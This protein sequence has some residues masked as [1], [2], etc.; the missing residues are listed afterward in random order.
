[1]LSAT[2]SCLSNEHGIGRDR[3]PPGRPSVT[4]PMSA[5][6]GIAYRQ[7]V[8]IASAALLLACVG[9]GGGTLT[10]ADAGPARC[11]DGIRQSGE[12]CDLGAK[13]GPNAGCERD[14]TLSCVPSDPRR[15]DA[16]CDPHDPCKGLG[17]CGSDFRCTLSGALASGA[18]CGSGNICRGGACQA[19]VCGD[20]IVTAPEE[21]DDGINDGTQG[22]DSHCRFTCF[23]TDPTRDCTPADPCQGPST[24]DDSTHTCAPRTPLADGTS[25]AGGKIC[26][27]GQC[28]PSLCGN[29]IVD[30]GEQCDPPNGTT[31][32]SNCQNIV[33]GDGVRS[34]N[35][36]CDDGNRTNLDGCDSSCRFEQEQRATAV[37]MV[38][39]TD[40]YCTANAL[41]AA[42]GSNAQTPLQDQI[43]AAVASGS[44]TLAF[45]VL[46]LSDL[47]GTN[48]AGITLGA[49]TG[50]PAAAP[51]FHHYDGT[52]DLDWW[53]AP[54][55]A[56]LDANRVPIAQ[57]PAGI[58]SKTLN[59]GPGHMNLTFVL[60]GG[61]VQLAGS[62]VRLR[63]SVG[64]AT[65]PTES[66]AAAPGHTPGEHLDRALTS[67]A[68]LGNG[69]LCGNI[70][71]ASLAAVSAPASLQSG[72]ANACDEGYTS[73]NDMLD[74][75]VGGCSKVFGFVTII[76]PTQ[77]DQVDASMPAAGAGGPYQLVSSGGK[78]GACNDKDGAAVTLATCLNAAA[79]SSA[80]T[81][82]ADR[83]ILK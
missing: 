69:E 4:Q 19:P 33:C 14:C 30:P 77:P 23:S 29:G 2:G 65:A 53:Y 31:C 56:D 68:S 70:S 45:Q 1:M 82:S 58:S 11:G 41:G 76:A 28:L 81:F 83:I 44:M 73:A 32:D 52:K 59:A 16:H 71:A 20:G 13:N 54:Q 51:P 10:G 46:G 75:L 18:A 50:S 7:P 26:R 34:G 42:I 15:G 9:C 3:A 37:Q 38:W 36:Q 12:E 39:G 61:P 66:T 79:Y 55:A 22:C 8:R 48:A 35:E 63:A 72:G 60:G 74:V 21:C 25:C 62:A 78:V 47:T 17:S 49:V 27:Q 43:N 24:C 57:L 67:F 40:A 64:D 5:P 6:P 80:L